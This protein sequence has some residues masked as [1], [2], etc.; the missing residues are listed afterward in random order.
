MMSYAFA[1]SCPDRH[2]LEVSLCASRED[3]FRSLYFDRQNSFRYQTTLTDGLRIET[4]A[5]Q[6]FL[7]DVPVAMAVDISTMCG[8]PMGCAF[9]AASAIPYRRNCT[10]DE[11]IQQAEEM[12]ARH[13]DGRFPKINVAFQGIGEPSLLAA[14]VASAAMAIRERDS[15]AVVNISTIGADLGAI[16]TWCAVLPEIDNLQF[17]CC[18]L[19]PNTLSRLSPNSPAPDDLVRMARSVVAREQVRKTNINYV[20]LSKINDSERDL[21]CL[22]EALAGSEVNLRLA[23]LNR[24]KSSDRARLSHVSRERTARLIHGLRRAG[25]ESY[26]FGAFSPIEISCGQLVSKYE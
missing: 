12:I 21:N 20:V 8:C 25:I 1:E 24:T 18:S 22:V 6:H 13:G 4:S 5:Y 11:M 23:Y 14:D 26:L 7:S 10:T 9:C 2:R 16:E 19:D 17:S 15:R 3:A